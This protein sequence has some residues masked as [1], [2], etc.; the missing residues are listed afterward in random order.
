MPH[1]SQEDENMHQKEF[2]T[3]PIDP[4]DKGPQTEFTHEVHASGSQPQDK[5]KAPAT[6]A[7]DDYEET[8]EEI[9]PAQFRLARKRPGSTKI[10]I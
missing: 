6:E 3:E 4:Q 8:E 1:V 2:R 5:G 7:N 9:Y 10:T